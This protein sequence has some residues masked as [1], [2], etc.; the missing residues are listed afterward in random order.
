MKKA[1]TILVFLILVN[2][3]AQKYFDEN[4]FDNYIDYTENK[5]KISYNDHK[6]E[7]SF[8]KVKGKDYYNY[9]IVKGSNETHWVLK[10]LYEG[11]FYGFDILKGDYEQVIKEFNKGRNYKK[12]E[13]VFSN[14]PSDN[15]MNDFKFISQKLMEMKLERMQRDEKN[16]LLSMKFDDD[17]LKSN[18][19][20]S[21]KIKILKNRN[22]DYSSLETLGEIIITEVGVTIKTDIPSLDLIRGSFDKSNS[23]ISERNLV[24]TINKGYGD[25]FS[26]V[27]NEGKSAGGLTIV[28]G[29]YS[30]T[31]TFLI[32]E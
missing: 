11:S 20:G 29:N 25:Y 22:I 28:I 31:A 19:L 15:L 5:L 9:L 21:Y 26:L 12:V 23:D 30:S 17:I 7:G 24:C 2:S 8:T 16:K 10:T 1:I 6:V 13:V 18:L 14:L 32:N 3:Y 4:N 27:I